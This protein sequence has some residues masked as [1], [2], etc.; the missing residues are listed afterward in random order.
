MDFPSLSIRKMHLWNITC[1]LTNR[2][3][4]LGKVVLEIAYPPLIS[5]AVYDWELV[6]II[7]CHI[8]TEIGGEFGVT[9][10]W[11]M[12]RTGKLWQRSSFERHV[13]IF[14]WDNLGTPA[15]N[16]FLALKTK[17]RRDNRKMDVKVTWC[18]NCRM[19]SL[20]SWTTGH[21]K[22]Y[23]YANLPHLRNCWFGWQGTVS[24][25]KTKWRG[26]IFDSGETLERETD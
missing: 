16:G 6:K 5:T 3:F 4:F 25:S 9:G 22:I 7:K 10:C 19:E 14:S 1:Q 20:D 26:R 24:H 2:F 23:V 18:I 12:A 8:Y 17:S 21:V 15:A 13:V 11:E